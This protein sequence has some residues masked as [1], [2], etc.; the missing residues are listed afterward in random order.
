[1]SVVTLD[2]L[3][4]QTEKTAYGETK[5]Q[6]A[7]ENLEIQ[8]RPATLKEAKF[9]TTHYHKFLADNSL[10]KSPFGPDILPPGPKKKN[11]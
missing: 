4:S 10:I 11:A 1:L 6:C 9:V 7:D 8:W 3:V 2:A 5:G